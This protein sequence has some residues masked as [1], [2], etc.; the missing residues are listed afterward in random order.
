[1][2]QIFTSYFAKAKH[3]D[4]SKFLVV[5]ISRYSPRGFAGVECKAFAP[6]R[7]LLASYKAGLSEECYVERYRDEMSLV[8]DL[9][10]EF[11]QLAKC[12]AGRDIVLCCFEGSN[13][14]CHRHILSD[15]VFE[16]FGY[17]IQELS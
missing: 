9:R 3:L 8:R 16:S 17:R 2:I 4:S 10:G 5:S 7:H 6:S 1:M 13:S 12:A 14:F 11:A 15:I